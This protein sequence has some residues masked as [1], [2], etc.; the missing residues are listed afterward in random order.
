MD[1]AGHLAAGLSHPG[2]VSIYDYGEEIPQDINAD[3]STMMAPAA[4]PVT[5]ILPKRVHAVPLR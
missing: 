2:I 4:K 3:E 1:E 5:H